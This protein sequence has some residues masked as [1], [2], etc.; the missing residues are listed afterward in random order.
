METLYVHTSFN[1]TST[2]IPCAFTPLG[3]LNEI[4]CEW[5]KGSR[6][7]IQCGIKKMIHIDTFFCK[8]ILIYLDPVVIRVRIGPQYR[9]WL[10]GGDLSDETVKIRKWDE[11][12]SVFERISAHKTYIRR[13]CWQ[14]KKTWKIIIDSYAS[15][16]AICLIVFYKTEKW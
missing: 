3:N 16:N 13:E 15:S 9:W 2:D 7:N 12:F 5:H 6:S 8:P 10:N 4:S 14:I 1:L 11:M